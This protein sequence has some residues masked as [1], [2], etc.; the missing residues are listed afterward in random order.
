MQEKVS[1]PPRIFFYLLSFVEKLFISGAFAV[2]DV[3]SWQN[4]RNTRRY[5]LIIAGILLL[6]LEALWNFLAAQLLNHV[7]VFLATYKIR[8]HVIAAVEILGGGLLTLLVIS[9]FQVA[10]QK[11][12]PEPGH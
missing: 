1:W 2:A 4:I 7:D 12:T 6:F 8:S 9:I 11:A 10:G 3:D 5:D